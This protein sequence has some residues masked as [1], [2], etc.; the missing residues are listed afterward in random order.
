MAR[1]EFLYRGKNLEELKSMDIKE[2]AALLPSRIR[3]YQK[4]KRRLIGWMGGRHLRRMEM[5]TQVLI[6]YCSTI[7][8]L[9]IKIPR[10]R[11]FVKIRQRASYLRLRMRGM[12]YSSSLSLYQ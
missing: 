11:T 7:V 12:L 9:T 4:I 1:K 8:G 2:F 6:H 3:R 5:T 10:Q